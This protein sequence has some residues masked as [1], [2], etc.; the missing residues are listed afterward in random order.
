MSYTSDTPQKLKAPETLW[1]VFIQAFHAYKAK[2]WTALPLT[3][4]LL[5]L[6]WLTT[7]LYQT[8]TDPQEFH[9]LSHG[10]MAWFCTFS[11]FVFAHK[12]IEIGLFVLLVIIKLFLNGA[13]VFQYAGGVQKS[14]G[15]A[16][17]SGLFGL[18]RSLKRMPFA[19]ITTIL[20]MILMAIGM[21]FAVHPGFILMVYLSLIT[22]VVFLENHN[23][24]K[25]IKTSA[26]LVHQNFWKTVL[27]S[28]IIAGLVFVFSELW[29]DSH[30]S[31]WIQGLFGLIDIVV[32][33]FFAAVSVTF[34]QYLHQRLANPLRQKFYQALKNRP[35]AIKWA[36]FLTFAY[37]AIT[38]VA[39]VLLAFKL[40]GPHA[41][42]DM[43]TF[44]A[45][46]DSLIAT[47]LMLGLSIVFMAFAYFGGHIARVFMII[48]SALVTFLFAMHLVMIS[49]DFHAFYLHSDL[50]YSHIIAPIFTLIFN[51]LIIVL[52]SS[53]SSGAWYR[54]LKAI[55]LNQDLE[56][57]KKEMHRAE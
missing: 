13:L 31:T 36:A 18:V 19:I 54:E 49:I 35:R 20:A 50:L 6:A 26:C 51:I 3:I 1:Q 22:P 53:S 52:L 10:F 8:Q 28:F 44:Y 2:F 39:F 27:V 12:A 55:R 40:V 7:S 11:E 33:G 21:L 57:L 34:Y 15:L 30:L 32:I 9:G 43:D 16:Q 37:V 47:N 56:C 5:A 48:A 29:K 42:D 38:F 25:T 4:L 46:L 45:L 41:K 24:I 23:P 14:Q 17:P